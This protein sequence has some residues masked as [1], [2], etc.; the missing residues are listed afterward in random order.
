LR[1]LGLPFAADAAITKH[2]SAF[3]GAH[4]PPTAVLFNGGVM[5]GRPFR[6]RIV[7]T[8]S[9]FAPAERSLR[10]LSGTDLD[11]AV[12]HGAG[13]YGL[14]RR[15][16]GVRIRGG[17]ARSYYIGIESSMPAVP[18]LPRP[19]KAL[20]VAPFGMEEGSEAELPGREFG[21]VVGEQAEFRFLSSSTRKQDRAGAMIDV[22]DE[23]MQEL[24]PVATV[25]GEEKGAGIHGGDVVPV[26]LRSKVTE[27][28]TL[29]LWCESSQANAK[30]GATGGPWKLEYN[31][32]EGN[33]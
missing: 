6:D 8:L 21:L 16:R 28:G 10:V 31:V 33:P 1:E 15:G 5:K 30:T 29:E 12:A 27:I 25:L 26:H 11:L 9:R 13:Y 32:R 18:G 22:V 2:L 17:T 7:E 20:C 19:L 3:V 23:S 24:A 14:V 4:R